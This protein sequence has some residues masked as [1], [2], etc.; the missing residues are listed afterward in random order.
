MSERKK[1]RRE[2]ESVFS[3]RKVTTN[4]RKSTKIMIKIQKMKRQT[5][6]KLLVSKEHPVC[7]NYCL[8]PQAREAKNI[9]KQG[10]Q[11]EL[12]G[13]QLAKSV[14]FSFS[15]YFFRPFKWIHSTKFITYFFFSQL[16]DDD[17][18]A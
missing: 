12:N 6:K 5:A 7:H 9:H 1:E 18:L 15:L 13:K 4:L 14:Y 10:T 11:G 17:V 2:K 16:Y 8:M 3:T